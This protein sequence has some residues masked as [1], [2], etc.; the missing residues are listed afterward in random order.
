MTPRIDID[1]WQA[2]KHAAQAVRHEVFVIGQHIPVELEWD[3]MDAR[4]LHAV[5]V[6]ETGRAVGTA[7]LLPD[8]HIGRMAV[9]ESE[10][11]KGIGS[12]LLQTMMEVARQRGAP[13]VMLNAQVD[14]M[15]FYRRHGFM[16]EGEVFD[17]AGIPHRLM[18]HRFAS[19]SQSS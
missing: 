14:A 9:L 16:E 1:D 2:L 6:D 17:D 12:R 11:G 13:E 15:P 10:R 4:S 8:F 19:S 7:R 5:A 18:R 3:D